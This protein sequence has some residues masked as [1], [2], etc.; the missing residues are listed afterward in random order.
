MGQTTI[1]QNFV[2]ILSWQENEMASSL[3]KQTNKKTG[4]LPS[5]MTMILFLAK[6]SLSWPS[7]HLKWKF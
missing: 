7:Q 1:R 2:L 3:P 6:Q 4:A 5:D